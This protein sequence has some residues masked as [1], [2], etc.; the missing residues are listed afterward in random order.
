[1][2]IEEIRIKNLLVLIEEAHS[3][4]N[5]AHKADTSPAYLSQIINKVASST[6]TP[7]GVG[8]KLAR[9]L[10]TGMKKPLGWLDQDHEDN[11]VV[12]VPAVIGSEFSIEI[13]LLDVTASMGNGENQNG[14]EIVI[15]V[16]RVCKSWI[17][18][19]LNP[20][21]DISNLSFIH[22]IGDSMYP[23]FNDGDI[24]LVD[25]GNN[26]AESDSVYVLEA[27]GR[28]FIKRVRR[29]MDGTFE[30]SSD[31]PAVKTVDVLNG[32]HDVIVKG[33][34]VWVWNGKKI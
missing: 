16:L 15:D 8:D 13:P 18:K 10:E 12:N 31:N 3:T 7:R 5:L 33:R 23:T 2:V 14:Q 29:R 20:I 30:I 26:N 22:A 19:S 34:V 21:T 9:K 32:S 24:L 17:E 4:A 6:G 11:D 27:H 1:M 28:L 25:S